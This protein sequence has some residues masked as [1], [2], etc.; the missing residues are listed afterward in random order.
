MRDVSDGFLA[1]EAE[2]A[3]AMIRRMD[4]LERRM[5]VWRLLAV[6]G[7][8]TALGAFGLSVFGLG[9]LQNTYFVGEMFTSVDLPRSGPNDPGVMEEGSQREALENWV[10]WRST[11]AGGIPGTGTTGDEF[12]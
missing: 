5:G 4:A 3:E 6:A 1:G 11:E 8:I 2:V 9:Q 10:V 12:E 7:L